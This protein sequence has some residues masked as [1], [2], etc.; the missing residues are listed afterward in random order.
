MERPN[1]CRLDPIYLSRDSKPFTLF[2]IARMQLFDIAGIT[3]I[4]QWLFVS[5]FVIPE[6]NVCRPRIQYSRGEHFLDWV[7]RWA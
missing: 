3:V 6:I 4:T 1:F 7:E 5:L 2:F